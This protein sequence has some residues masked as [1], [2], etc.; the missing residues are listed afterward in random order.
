MRR[1]LPPAAPVRPFMPR[2]LRTHLS[3]MFVF[4]YAP[5]VMLIVRGTPSAVPLAEPKLDVMS[6]RTTPLSVSTLGPFEP[7]PG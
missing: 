2:A 6:L 7:S 3:L 4:L 5:I 1:P